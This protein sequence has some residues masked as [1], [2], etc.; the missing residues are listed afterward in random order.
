[1]AQD[2]L[3]SPINILSASGD[4]FCVIE[5]NTPLP[6]ARLFYFTTIVDAQTTLELKVLKGN[7]LFAAV[8][9]SG[10]PPAPP[11]VVR[12]EIGFYVDQNETLTFTTKDYPHGNT[13]PNQ[14]QYEPGKKE[15]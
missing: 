6:A 13:L 9:I 2:S 4:I 8:H 7:D 10:I 11:G 3:I 15:T 12:I 14:I 5:Q 1:M